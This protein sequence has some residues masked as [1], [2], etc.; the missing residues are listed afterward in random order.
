MPL[1]IVNLVTPKAA[2]KHELK[3]ALVS[4]AHHFFKCEDKTLY[5][6]E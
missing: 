3:T 4:K 6:N 2:A 1:T 5:D